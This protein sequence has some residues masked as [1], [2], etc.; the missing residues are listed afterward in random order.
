MKYLLISLIIMPM[1][2]FL[3]SR[4]AQCQDDDAP[5]LEQQQQAEFKQVE[6]KQ[7]MGRL[8]PQVVV[9]PGP[10]G[11]PGEALQLLKDRLQVLQYDRTNAVHQGKPAAEI[12][13]IDAQIR[14]IQQQMTAYR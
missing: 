8:Q 14:D 9:Q 11:G 1:M 3:S 5:F 10:E 6:T 7:N 12:A 4:F 2:L 13:Q